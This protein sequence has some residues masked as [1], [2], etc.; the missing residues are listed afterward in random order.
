MRLSLIIC[1]Y[2]TRIELFRQCLISLLKSTLRP[3]EVEIVV[4]DDG[5]DVDYSELTLKYRLNYI[6]SE[7]LSDKQHT[8]FSSLEKHLR[9][10]LRVGEFLKPEQLLQLQ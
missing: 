6:K 9:L 2:N 5:S 10:D 4:I 1:L 7:S 3:S 8:L